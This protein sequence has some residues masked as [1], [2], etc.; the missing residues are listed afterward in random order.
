MAAFKDEEEV[1]EHGVKISEA[2]E[3]VHL[4]NYVFSVLF[5]VCVAA[6]SSFIIIL[7]PNIPFPYFFLA[8]F[9]SAF[10]L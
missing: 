4:N 3:K 5:F 1:E 9:D 2:A 7:E 8:C 10:H 6:R